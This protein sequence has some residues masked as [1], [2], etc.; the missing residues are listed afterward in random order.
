MNNEE[1]AYAMIDRNIIQKKKTNHKR[2]VVETVGIL[3]NSFNRFIPIKV[4]KPL[5]QQGLLSARK[6]ENILL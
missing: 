5:R 4:I 6:Y 2:T 3:Q 1:G